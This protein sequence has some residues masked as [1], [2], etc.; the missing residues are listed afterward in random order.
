MARP[1]K[2]P[3]PIQIEPIE[4]TQESTQIEQP[5]NR[6]EMIQIEI[7]SGASYC[8]CFIDIS[9]IEAHTKAGWRIKPPNFG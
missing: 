4:P 1:R 5:T 2:N 9:Q 3:E 7:G 8:T 6:G